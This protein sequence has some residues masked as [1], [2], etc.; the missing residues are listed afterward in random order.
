[1]L[2]EHYPLVIRSEELDLHGVDLLVVD[3]GW[4]FGIAL[5]VQTKAA[6]QW[7][8]VKQRRH[9]DPPGLPVLYLYVDQNGYRVGDFWLHSPAQVDDV[10]A[11]IG[12]Q[13]ADRVKGPESRH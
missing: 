1:M 2:K 12:E 9:H 5:S 13:K 4:A 7:Q 3:D 11:I 8:D 10:W 6:H